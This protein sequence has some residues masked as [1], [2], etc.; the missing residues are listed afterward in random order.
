[1]T[2]PFLF[3]DAVLRPLPSLTFCSLVQTYFLHFFIS[4]SENHYS[5]LC[6]LFLASRVS[7]TPFFPNSCVPGVL[8]GIN[9]D[10]LF[11]PRVVCF[12]TLSSLYSTRPW[13]LFATLFSKNINSFPPAGA[14]VLRSF[15]SLSPCP[16]LVSCRSSTPL[17]NSSFV[18]FLSSYS[19]D[20]SFLHAPNS[21]PPP[22]L[23]P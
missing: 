2:H 21:L 18:F 23:I 20:P 3:Q 7:T 15:L 9:A 13:I 12:T 19:F 14:F 6:V 16:F 17:S 8:D 11:Y 4:S 5:L 1:M 22:M 10:P